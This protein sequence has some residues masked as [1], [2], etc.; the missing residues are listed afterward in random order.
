MIERAPAGSR[1]HEQR[2]CHHPLS[3]R[4]PCSLRRRRAPSAAPGKAWRSVATTDGTASCRR[5]HRLA[6]GTRSRAT[7]HPSV[8]IGNKSSVVVGKAVL[9]ARA[10]VWCR[11]TI[12]TRRTRRAAP[13]STAF[14]IAVETYSDC[15]SQCRRDAPCAARRRHIAVGSGIGGSTWVSRLSCSAWVK[16]ANQSVMVWLFSLSIIAS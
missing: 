11:W 4:P 1:E 9:S 2:P 10:R 3:S 15:T 12:R 8:I 13:F 16:L 7:P 6:D 14:P 5:R